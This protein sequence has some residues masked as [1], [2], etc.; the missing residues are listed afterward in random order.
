[1]QHLLDANGT[2]LKAA[3]EANDQTLK[4]RLESHDSGIEQRFVIQQ[5]RADK[6]AAAL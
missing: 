6:Q 3:V 1:M 5:R 2:A 4:A